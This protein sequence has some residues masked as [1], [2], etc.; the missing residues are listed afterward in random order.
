MLRELWDVIDRF[1]ASVVDSASEAV[2]TRC[3]A[4]T[5]RLGAM[6]LPYR[7]AHGLRVMIVASGR[8]VAL[9]VPTCRC[10]DAGVRRLLPR[11]RDGREQRGIDWE[12]VRLHPVDQLR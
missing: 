8:D 12:R 10:D 4:P 1:G 5:H 9:L 11:A 2:M 6:R 7:P 3:I